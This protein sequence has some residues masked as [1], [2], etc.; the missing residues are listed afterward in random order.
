M[1]SMIDPSRLYMDY[2]EKDNNMAEIFPAA[3]QQKLNEGGFTQKL[4]DTSVRSDVDTGLAKT[5]QRYTKPVDD[6]SCTIDLEIDDYNTLITFYRTTL[7]G[8]SRTFYYDHPMTGLESE[9]RFKSPPTMS[10]MGGLWF[11]VNMQWE[12]IPQ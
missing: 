8:G 11:K 3:L 1:A 5:R 10:P 4:G 7:A 12:E 6:F 2:K 9:F